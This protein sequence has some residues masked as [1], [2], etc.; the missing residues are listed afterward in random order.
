MGTGILFIS[1]LLVSVLRI[2]LH[3]SLHACELIAEFVNVDNEFVTLFTDW[4]GEKGVRELLWERLKLTSYLD[5]FR[6]DADT[7]IF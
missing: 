3:P 1:R 4:L 6:E 2:Y 5:A 7:I